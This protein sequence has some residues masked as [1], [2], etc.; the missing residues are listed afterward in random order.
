MAG[1]RPRIHWVV[2]NIGGTP[3][4]IVES[5]ATI[6]ISGPTIFEPVPEYDTDTM[7]MGAP[8]INPGTFVEFTKCH[9]E[10]LRD[11]QTDAM[12]LLQSHSY[13]IGYIRYEDDAGVLRYMAFC[14]RYN[15][16]RRRFE[17]VDDPNYEYGD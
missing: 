5:N 9:D 3:G 15:R 4:R 6:K 10:E 16:M 7:S 11:C 17:M 8:S 13:L 2:A 14:R 12:A 1:Q